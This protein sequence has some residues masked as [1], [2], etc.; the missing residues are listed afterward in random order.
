MTRP[1]ITRT[2]GALLSAIFITAALTG[3]VPTAHA[4]TPQ[5]VADYDNDTYG[6]L[7]IGVPEATVNTYTGAGLAKVVYGNTTGLDT[8]RQ[9]LISQSTTGMPGASEA[10]DAFGTALARGDF[11]GDG[12]TDLAISQPGEDLGTITDAGA[13][14]VMTANGATL[15]PPAHLLTLPTSDQAP[16]D[17]LGQAM[18]AGDFN[19]DGKAELLAMAPGS[20][21]YLIYSSTSG[22]T[23]SS[24]QTQPPTGLR[25]TASGRYTTHTVH[26]TDHTGRMASQAAT[27]AGYPATT[28]GDLNGDGYDDA[29]INYKDTDG[30]AYLWI[31]YGSPTGLATDTATILSGGGRSLATGDINNDGYDDIL[32]GLP[33]E[34]ITVNTT[35]NADAGAAIILYGSS[36]GLTGTGAQAI[37]QDDTGLGAIEAGDQYGSAVALND[38]THDGHA[39]L[40]IGAA[41]E[42]TGDGTI[43]ILQGTTTGPLI[44]GGQALGPTTLGIGNGLHIGSVLAP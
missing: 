8:A 1:A 42:N 17:Q 23:A 21:R 30:L 18:T 33:G 29:V 4:A 7:A 22:L 12:D 35:S 14:S 44:P 37:T 20:W 19:G 27:P 26:R 38:H 24:T 41:G 13:I 3:P 40:A 15:T 10:G 28:A 5:P 39:D 36:S 43:H 34:D 9:A 2:G 6:D 16:G 32:T 11:D 31:A 25:L